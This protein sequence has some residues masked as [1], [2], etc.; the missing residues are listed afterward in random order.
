M[1]KNITNNNNYNDD[2]IQTLDGLTHMQKRLGMY[3]GAEPAIHC[4]RE[5]IDNSIDE[6]MN[7]FADKIDVV[8][9][10]KKNNVIIIDNGRGIP[11]G[12][13]SKGRPTLQKV[14][15]DPN[16]GGKFNSEAFKTSSGLHG[17]GLKI[18]TAICDSLHAE[19]ERNGTRVAI[20]FSEGKTTKEFRKIKAKGIN[21]TLVSFT[22]SKKFLKDGKDIID[23]DKLLNLCKMRSFL[24]KGSSILLTIDN[25]KYNF[26]YDNGMAEYLDEEIKHKLFN[27]EVLMFEGTS[28]N[29]WYEITLCYDGDSSEEKIES[30]CNGILNSS[31]TH[32]TGFKTAYTNI[33]KKFINDNDLLPKKNKKLNI[34]G[35]DIRKGLRVVLNC[36]I[37]DPIYSSQTKDAISNNEVR[38]EINEL[39]TNFLTEYINENEK[40]FKKICNRIIQFAAATE[41]IKKAQE[42]I[43]KNSGSSSLSFSQKYIP[44]SSKEYNKCELFIVEGQSA[45]G[46]LRQERDTEFQALYSIRGK[47]PNTFGATHQK[48]LDNKETEE[49]MRIIF[50][51][52][53]LKIINEKRTK[54]L[55][56][57]K[58]VSCADADDDG[59]HVASLIGLYIEEHFPWL[60]EEGY[61]YNACPP[62]YKISISSSEYRYFKNVKE[63]NKFKAEYIENKYSLENTSLTMLDIVTKMDEY[64]QEVD[65]IAHDKA[66]PIDLISMILSSGLKEALKY[67]KQ[68]KISISKRNNNYYAQGLL[69]TDWLDVEFSDEL[70]NDINSLSNIYGLTTIEFINNETNEIMEGDIYDV[71][72]VFDKAFKFTPQRFKGLG[73]CKPIDL[74]RTV[75]NPTER[76]IVKITMDNSNKELARK[77]T[78]LFFGNNADLRKDFI[79]EN[80]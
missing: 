64:K 32:E 21:G 74:K 50:G 14:F 30:Y 62:L 39:V 26:K 63:F 37:K 10:T 18:C 3:A 60:I 38:T 80:L 15:Q 46:P 17:V 13:D 57:G 31:G 35:D 45:R 52:N 69:D 5:I 33:I 75:L 42:K 71:L 16:T 77:D 22:P 29:N 68:N 66:L 7:G 56:F 54:L 12:R 51:T 44:C 43:V 36:K 41:N 20:D 73:E 58:I 70:I 76:D 19:S 59:Y 4:V 53:D 28:E 1:T 9:D 79:K 2:S 34:T 23:K 48:L 11:V 6:I 55:R 27:M 78:K 24:N 47:L 25:N 72:E 49:L 61:F 40:L 67:L 65:K 8:L